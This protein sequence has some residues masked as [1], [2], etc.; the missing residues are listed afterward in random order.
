[1]ISPL[2]GV[3]AEYGTGQDIAQ[4]ALTLLPVDSMSL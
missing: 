1:M 3:D 2:L 4:E